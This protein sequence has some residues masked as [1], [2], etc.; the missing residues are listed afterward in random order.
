MPMYWAD[1]F[2]DTHHLTH[3]QHGIYCLLIGTYWLRG[4]LPDDDEQLAQIA[5]L[6]IE[7]WRFHR[8]VINRFFHSGWKH[9]RIDAE[10]ER[11]MNKIEKRRVAGSKGG[12]IAS[13]NRFRKR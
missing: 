10:I 5:H 12:T 1:Y 6:T 3:A 13:I 7:E 4:S 9:T 2:A 11:T 8:P